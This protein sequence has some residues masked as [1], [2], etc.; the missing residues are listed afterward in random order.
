M[1]VKT[2]WISICLNELKRMTVC[3]LRVKKA[4][5]KV[6]KI[7]LAYKYKCRIKWIKNSTNWKQIQNSQ[8]FS[9]FRLFCNGPYALIPKVRIY[10]YPF[11]KW[12][13]TKLFKNIPTFHLQN[14]R[15]FFKFYFLLVILWKR[16]GNL[17]FPLFFKIFSLHWKILFFE[18]KSKEIKF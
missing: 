4:E 1:S 17:N 13:W 7:I 14:I 6:F 18:V 10:S 16:L 11:L 12:L 5:S 8:D 15:L 3:R 2:L 9:D